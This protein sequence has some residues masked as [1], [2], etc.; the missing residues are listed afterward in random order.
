[1]APADMPL[2]VL[3]DQIP[4]A[5]ISLEDVQSYL[6]A[7]NPGLVIILDDACRS[8]AG[9]VINRKN[10]NNENLVLKGTARQ[11]RPSNLVNTL[12]GYAAKS[13]YSAAGYSTVGVPSLFTGALV[14]YVDSNARDFGAIFHDASTDVVTETG[15]EQWPGMEDWSNTDLYLRAS[16][17][18]EAQEKEMWL[19]SLSEGTRKAVIRFSN[20]HSVSRYAAAARKWLD[21][22]PDDPPA[23]KFTYLSPAVIERAWNIHDDQLAIQPSPDGWAFERSL[24]GEAI[25]KLRDFSNVQLGIADAVAVSPY[26]SESQF[27]RQLRV[28]QAHDTLI[29]TKTLESRDGPSF[30][31][32]ATSQ[33]SPGTPVKID[34]FEFSENGQTWLMGRTPNSSTVQYF[35]VAK[36]ATRPYAQLRKALIEIQTPPRKA[37]VPDLVE[38]GPIQQ[39]VKSI[40][41]TSEKVTW[42]SL[43][44]AKTDDAKEA[45]A[46]LARQTHAVY[47]LK[48][49]GI[50]ERRITA[51]GP[52]DDVSGD[53]VR[54]RFFGY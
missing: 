35:P 5:A 15:G 48:Q 11:V 43:T 12:V 24:S 34:G 30:A 26:P 37:G 18:I 17:S 14:N 20:R 40:R 25:E 23:A 50:D 6:A 29:A 2:S 13:G 4:D 38:A 28:L 19:A 27:A 53:G 21:D 10:D 54:V 7:R 1:V 52:S 22:N 9:F 39:A 46:R 32:A 16:A 42:V 51:A 49:A 8:I 31:S 41:K 44:V 33:I 47:L 36:K 45:D 3:N